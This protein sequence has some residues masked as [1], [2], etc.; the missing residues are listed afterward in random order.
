MGEG[1]HNSE[2]RHHGTREMKYMQDWLAEWVSCYRADD[3]PLTGMDNAIPFLK[4]QD[5][6]FYVLAGTYRDDPPAYAFDIHETP[7]I[8]PLHE[9]F[10]DLVVKQW[11][12]RSEVGGA[13]IRCRG[14]ASGRDRVQPGLEFGPLPRA[15]LPDICARPRPAISAGFFRRSF[16]AKGHHHCLAV[17]AFARSERL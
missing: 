17:L 14:A 6:F 16:S 10:S 12:P 2:S 11:T 15:P 5:T 9:R 3:I 13:A 4:F 1:P 8:R 7:T